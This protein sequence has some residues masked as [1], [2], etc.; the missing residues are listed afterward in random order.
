MTVEFLVL[1]PIEAHDDGDVLVLGGPQQR[2]LLAV[3]LSSPGQVLSFDRLEETVWPNGDAPEGAR[4]TLS[5]YI[6]RLRTALGDGYVAKREA[7]YAL[8]SGAA[9]LDAATFERLVESAR[10]AAPTVRLAMLDQALAMWRG[11][12]F[13]EFAGEWWARPLA[14]RLEELRLI[15]REDRIE[16]LLALGDADRAVS[17]GEGFA[18]EYPLRERPVAQLMRAL[19]TNGRQAEAL[20]AYRS[21]RDYLGEQTGLDPSP[22]L[23]ELERSIAAGSVPEPVGANR[24]ARGYVLGDVLGQGSFGT[25]YR[26]TQPG[27]GRDVAVKV[28]RSELANDPTFVQ[29]FEAEAQLVARLEHPHIVPL[30]DFWREPGGA[31]LVF[32]LMRGGSAEQLLVT[33]GAWP[34]ER[35]TQVLEQIGGALA[36]AHAAGVIHRDVKP[37]NVL[38]DDAGNAHLADFGIASTMDAPNV[39]SLYSAGSPL[40]ASPEQF[41]GLGLSARSDLYSFGAMVWELLAGAP[42]FDG[43]SATVIGRLKLER[44]VP[45]LVNARPDLATSI[46]AVLQKATAVDP[47]DRFAS[48]ADLVLAWHSAVDARR[49]ASTD[50]AGAGASSVRLRAARTMTELAAAGVNPYK[51]LR[52]FTEAD[53]ADFFGRAAQADGLVHA[54]AEAR[55]T[56]VVGASG[57]GKSSLVHAGLL[58]RLRR[59]GARI[60]TMVPTERPCDQLHTALLAVAVQPLAPVL[61]RAVE[62]VADEAVSDLVIVVDQFE[63]VW[64]LAD[65]DERE[66]FVALLTRLATDD[67]LN[68]RLVCAIRADFYDRP[69]SEPDLGPIVAQHAFSI[70]PMSA[71]ELSEAV[72]APANAAGVSFE[73]GLDAEIVADVANQSASLPMLQ[74][75]LAELYEH[76]RGA[77]IP[78]SAYREMGGVAGAVAARAESVFAALG[79]TGQR[80]AR[81][82]FSRLVTPG[83][84]AE[85]TRRRARRSE[86]PDTANAIAD[87]FVTHRLL[88][89]DRD[90]ATREP[91]VDIAHEA[92]LTRWPRL[93][94]WLDDDRGQLQLMQHVSVAAEEWDDAGRRETDLYRGP[95]LSIVSEI[96]DAG[97]VILSPTEEEFLTASRAARDTEEQAETQRIAQQARQNRR[98]RRALVGA[99]VA[100]VLALVAGTIAYTQ[101]NSANDQRAVA[102]E[103]RALAT[104]RADESDKAR[105]AAQ[106]AS[107]TGDIDRMV[108]QSAAD[109]TEAPARAALLA[110]EA[111]RRR[112]DWHTAGAMQ[113]VLAQIP[114][115][116]LTT[117]N[118]GN[119]GLT[120]PLQ[121]GAKVL[122]AQDGTSLTI[123]DAKTFRKR[124]MI[125]LGAEVLSVS[126]SADEQFAAASDPDGVTVVAVESGQVVNRLT[127]GPRPTLAGFDPTDSGRLAVVDAVEGLE[128]NLQGKRSSS[129]G[130][131]RWRTGQFDWRNDALPA[132][133]DGAFSP[134]GQILVTSHVDGTARLWDARSGT[135]LLTPLSVDPVPTGIAFS[136]FSPNSKLVASGRFT[137]TTKVWNVVDGSVVAEIDLGPTPSSL[138]TEFADD[139]TLLI[140]TGGGGVGIDLL[141]KKHLP[142]F[143]A[144]VGWFLAHSVPIE[145]R[146]RRARHRSSRS[147]LS[148]LGRPGR[149]YRCRCLPALV[150][151]P[152]TGS[153]DS[154]RTLQAPGSW[155]LTPRLG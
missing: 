76:R 78:T 4:R 35:V 127:L 34:L 70:A 151:I 16:A 30:Y 52:S 24:F 100:L 142:R 10:A 50:E 33:D 51:G 101:R 49:F 141:T 28:I 7:G 143:E 102:D 29:R 104:Q 92:L 123:W 80:D 62:F 17:E 2:R 77:V 144:G 153:T 27:V 54:V 149:G 61:E 60:A 66:R 47:A 99:G 120:Y 15:A 107:D 71:A 103:Q 63:E 113:S 121:L 150:E 72:R 89:V 96:S 41:Q 82:L 48:A 131:V 138:D 130:T 139:N 137:G 83:A 44:P 132:G 57:S 116:T 148:M 43:D 117:I 118:R 23:T 1:G 58:P 12:A 136:A 114:K 38:F 64:T 31:Y 115:G 18:A 126:L 152:A 133:I 105:T 36:V 56:I 6:S 22:A 85:D 98:L 67:S 59:N 106:L 109:A 125:D 155:P 26:A 97:N 11:P 93:R 5:T 55:L 32:R 124:H 111:Y 39:G 14:T 9:P 13:G 74:F 79:E 46:D 91:T 20:R 75:A 81:R 8:D 146:W 45:S 42:P 87:E 134:D 95:R 86:L 3:L 110:V 154:L 40:Y 112:G 65:I 53:S 90:P 119:G 108:A 37:A 94:G 69:L 73:P 84:G 25:V 135:A 19:V 145:K 122:V 129:V 128:P 140:G 21:F 147:E 88:V 68:V